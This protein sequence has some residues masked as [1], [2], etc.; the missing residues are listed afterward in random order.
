MLHHRLFFTITAILQFISLYAQN[1]TGNTITV[2]QLIEKI[3]IDSAIV[4][5][6]VRTPEELEG[7][8]GKLNN[9]INIP[10]Q[11]LEGRL[12]ELEKFKD[13]EIAVICRTGRRSA[14]ATEILIRN[15]FNARNVLGGMVEFR[16]VEKNNKK[17]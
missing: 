2:I 7:L 17:H 10:V 16:E 4:I 11:E 5:L 9:V 12:S 13:S 1:D 14:T 15:G 6:D 3:A 8:L